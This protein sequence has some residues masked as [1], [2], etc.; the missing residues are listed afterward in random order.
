[1]LLRYPWP[2]NVRELRAEVARWSVFAQDVVGPDDLAPAI[3]AAKAPKPKSVAPVGPL[4]AEVAALE[5][6]LV[7]RALAQAGGN[8][9]LTARTLEIDRNTL[10]R[11]LRAYGLGGPNRHRRTAR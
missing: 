7:A 10:K 5:A 8:L 6:Q 3:R 1:L 9:S 2:G 4:V 11:K